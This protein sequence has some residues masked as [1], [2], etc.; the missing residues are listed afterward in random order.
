MG[1][2]FLNFAI[3]CL[4]AGLIWLLGMPS[5]IKAGAAKRRGQPLGMANTSLAVS[6]PDS[7]DSSDIGDVGVPGSV[8]YS[9][10]T[11]VVTG[12]GAD[13][14]GTADEFHY[15]YQSLTGDGQIMAR[16]MDI[17]AGNPE[18]KG[19][20]MI[21]E[22]LAAGARSAALLM[23]AMRTVAF[24]A[25]KKTNR[26]TISKAE[27]SASAP[28]WIMLSRY[29]DA[30]V[31]S[32]SSDGLDWQVLETVR[33]RMLE[34]VYVGLAVSS[35][36]RQHLRAV[37][38]DNVRSTG[39]KAGTLASLTLNPTSVTGGT[40]ASGVVTLSAVAPSGGAVVAV[41]DS[42]TTVTSA[43]T[44]VTVPAGS[45]STAFSITTSEVPGDTSALFTATYGGNSKSATLNV[46]APS[47]IAVSSLTLGAASVTGGNSA[48]GRVLLTGAAPSGGAVVTLSTSNAAV[49]DVPDSVTVA[50][51]SSSMSFT[52]TTSPV[53]V[54]SSVTF[55]AAYDGTTGT[56]TLTVNPPTGPPQSG[57]VNYYVATTGS[58][59]NSGTI[60]QP[61]RTI[62]RAAD[63]VNPGDTVIVDD[64]VYT[65]SGTN[66][67]SPAKTIVCTTR[68]GIATNWVV[69]KSKNRWGA[70]IDGQNNSVDNGWAFQSN[71]GYIRIEGF[72]FYGM[73]SSG[74]SSS[75]IE[76]YNGGHDIELIGNHIHDVGRQCTQTINGLV[77]IYVKQNQVLIEQNSIHDIGRYAPG[78]NGCSYP[79]GYI[80]YQTHDHAMYLSAGDDVTILNNVV[81]NIR[82]GWAVQVFPNS[83]TRLNILNNTFAFG[84]PNQHGHI[85]LY[86]AS[87]TD[88]NIKNNVFYQPTVAAIY[89][90]GGATF[91]NTTIANNLTD[92]GQIADST[93]SGIAFS[94]NQ[95]N[96]NPLFLN[97]AGLD[98][99]LQAASPAVDTGQTLALVTNDYEGRSRPAGNAYDRGAYE[100]PSTTAR[101][102][103]IS[104]YDAI[105]RILARRQEPAGPS[106]LFDFRVQKRPAPTRES[107][108]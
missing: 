86:Q 20:V 23:T 89:V 47:A 58:D 95:V 40:P 84:N 53:S 29:G 34:T 21:R 66:Y 57:G 14:A 90:G 27:S 103:A 78:E 50:S 4:A 74:G 82:R 43:P 98:F 18:A 62:Q 69:F 64:G 97:A 15:V 8:D 39:K 22:S 81:Y 6:L 55:T 67:C 19:G 85:V 101:A 38:F 65:Y 17:G 9:S 68:G 104:P 46:T 44:S 77:G 96:T 106:R 60:T 92:V 105:A 70:K 79:A 83:R 25:R 94:N 12:A 71:A 41:A 56:A 35:R 13:I 100:Y 1:N 80:G 5:P 2:R 32:I 7:W 10:G 73:G 30:F 91:N 48:Q 16:V 76:A 51:G 108:R 54:S 33:V 37:A 59:T 107:F 61:L 87:I 75:A 26:D 45:T 24:Q 72:E 102:A 88:S 99:H 42:N 31:A 36:D 11:F 49:A 93:P 63:L 28:S 3:Y 52:I